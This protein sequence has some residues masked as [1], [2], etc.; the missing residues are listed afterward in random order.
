MTKDN[1]LD[2]LNSLRKSSIVEP[3][4]KSIGTWNARQM[5]FLKFFR[6]LCS[7][8][9]PDVRRRYMPVCMKG[10]KQIPRKELS[11]YKPDI[12]T[13][14][15]NAIFLKYCPFPH[16]RCYHAMATDTYARPHELLNLRSQ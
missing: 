13:S 1:I 16:D 11:P 8:N 3:N 10:I 14:E 4:H 15:E 5:L 9:E 6:W 7:P 12:L 2:Y